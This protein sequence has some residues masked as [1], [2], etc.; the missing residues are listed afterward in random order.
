MIY[1][2]LK[3]MILNIVTSNT[4]VASHYNI[5]NKEF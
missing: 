2:N 3:D 5:F 1:N 4:S